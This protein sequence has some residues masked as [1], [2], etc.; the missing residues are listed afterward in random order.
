MILYITLVTS[1]S[2]RVTINNGSAMIKPK[3]SY[4]PVHNSAQ[5]NRSQRIKEHITDR[6]VCELLVETV[7]TP[8]DKNRNEERVLQV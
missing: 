8:I 2:C 1:L 3:Y 7:N 4:N 6:L 5:N